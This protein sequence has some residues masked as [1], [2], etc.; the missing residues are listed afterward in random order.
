MITILF[1]GNCQLHAVYETLNL[2]HELYKVHNIPCWTTTT[3]QEEFTNIVRICDIIVTQP[4]QDKYR[5]LDY[6][7]TKYIM[8]HASKKCKIIIFDSCHFDFYYFDLTYTTFEENSLKK[9]IDYHYHKMMQYYR[10]EKSQETYLKEIVENKEL[11]TKEELE[12]IA[13]ASLQELQ[14]RFHKTKEKY[15]QENI[16]LITI[17]DYV[18]NNY[19]EKLLFYSMNHPTKYVIQYICEEICKIAGWSNSINYNHDILSNPKCILYKCV[20]NAVNFDVEK[21]TPFIFIPEIGNKKNYVDIT[22]L[23]YETYKE[24]GF[25]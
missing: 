7:N 10:E 25:T 14:K 16:Y 17:H 6:L 21:H 11:K 15:D 13:E 9:P 19:K 18:K 24:I 2:S 3:T 8:E 20:Q 12:A 1:Y 22:N 23:Y 4:I 5:D